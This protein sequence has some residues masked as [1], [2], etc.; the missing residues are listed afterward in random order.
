[1]SAALPTLPIPPIPDAQAP[2]I[3]THWLSTAIRS[4][5]RR[6]WAPQVLDIPSRVGRSAESTN[7]AIISIQALRDFGMIDRAEAAWALHA[8]YE[9]CTR[10]GRAI[11]G[12]GTEAAFYR[13]RAEDELADLVEGKPELFAEL[14]SDGCRSLIEG[15]GRR[16][17]AR[18]RPPKRV[19]GILP[20]DVGSETERA[21]LIDAYLASTFYDAW[22]KDVECARLKRAMNA[23]ERARGL[24]PDDAFPES[25]KPV[26]W[27]LLAARLARRMDAIIAFWL[28]QYGEH[29]LA[30]LVIERP[31]EYERLVDGGSFRWRKVA[32]LSAP[33]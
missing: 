29:R 23:L 2:R 11:L 5:A 18:T 10:F 33:F 30:M 9:S 7:A 32:S 24:Q 26:E 20:H 31:D 25:E 3:A 16:M 1:M 19:Q 22:A 14:C 4:S 13:A 15:G 12:D 21:R 8:I 28:R 27:T 17:R 6:S